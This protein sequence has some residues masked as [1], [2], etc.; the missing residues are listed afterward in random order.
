[1]TSL[2]YSVTGNSKNYCDSVHIKCGRVTFWHFKMLLY[3][4][5]FLFLEIAKQKKF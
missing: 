4:S 3:S 2:I 1:M 5:N